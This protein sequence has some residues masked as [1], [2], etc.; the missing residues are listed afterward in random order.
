MNFRS[1]FFLT[2]SIWFCLNLNA[3][4][5]EEILKKGKE[6]YNGAGSCV[7]CHMAD[8]NGQKGNIPPLAGSEWLKGGSD[9]SIAISLRG[10]AGPIKVN[11]KKYYAAMPPQLL[12]NDEKLA[13]ILSYVNNAWGN[14]EDLVS[15]EQVAKARSELP[16]DVFTPQ[17]LLKKYPFDKKYSK[18]NGTFTPTFD[19]TLTEIT[20]PVIYR[21]FMPG[22]SPAAF[23]VALPGNHYFCWDAGEC[24]LRYVW[25]KGGFIKSNQAH[26][27]SNGKP[28]AEFNGTPYY[29]AQ[30]SL[31]ED[32]SFDELSKTNMEMPIYDTSQAS[33][34]P[35]S[36]EGAGQTPSFLGYQ[37]V[38]GYP[39]F[40]YSLGKHNITELL[41]MNDEKNG[42]IRTF[43][44]SPPAKTV[45]QLAPSAS[46][47]VKTNRGK[48]TTEGTL[49]LSSSESAQ[50]SLV[51]TPIAEAN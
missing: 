32:E 37:L 22:A 25:T 16:Q 44:I 18:K 46:A 6:L 13:Y 21:T 49:I 28:V 4:S 5:R 11:G 29:R 12:F 15:K 19:D 14:R 43:T 33:D 31:L 45:F 17:T 34:F 39:K 38:D 20:R 1:L 41:T 35:I 10:L 36:I 26:W 23:A 24:R 27:S 9:R 8:G 7:A 3:E 40:R 51:I 30:T 42:I 2:F 48:I 50:F 47:S